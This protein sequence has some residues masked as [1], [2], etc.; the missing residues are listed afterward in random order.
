MF[1]DKEGPWIV[2]ILRSLVIALFSQGRNQDLNL[3]KQKYKTLTGH[4]VCLKNGYTFAFVY[5]SKF[6]TIFFGTDVSFE[7]L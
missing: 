2:Q 5:S 6:V 4:K 3:V 7:V 1:I